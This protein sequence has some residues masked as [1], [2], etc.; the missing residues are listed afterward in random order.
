MPDRVRLTIDGRPAEAEPGASLL[1]VL[2]NEGRWLARTS[3]SGERRGPLC[4]MGACF[5]CRVTIDGE[6]HRRSCV[7]TVREGMEVSLSSRGTSAYPIPSDPPALTLTLADPSSPDTDGAPRDDRAMTGA[8]RNDGGRF[9]AEVVVVGGGPAGLAAAVHAAEAGARTLLLDDQP[10]SGGQ[11]WRHRGDAPPCAR[12]WLL[13]LAGSRAITLAAAPVVDTPSPGELLLERHGRPV[14]V[15]Y[16]RLVLAMGARELFLPFPGWT[17]PGVVGAGGASALLKAGASFDGRRV[18]VAGSGPLLVAVAAELRRAGARVVG[19]AEQ[20]SFPRLAAFAAGLWREP[21][22]LAEG[23]GHAATL[24]GVPYRTGAWVSEAVG[25]EAVERVAVTDGRREWVWECDVLACGFG[26]VP[27]LELA[28]LLGCETTSEG[29]TVGRA[30]QTSRPGVFAAGEVC[31][32][33]GVDHALAAGAIAGLAAA[34]RP[35]PGSLVARRARGA[36]FATRLARAFA[37]RDE[38]RA[39]A[40]HDTTVCRCED[41]PLDR[42]AGARSAREAKLH[43]RVGMGPCQGRVCGPALTFLHGWAPDS[44]RPP[45]LPVPLSVLEEDA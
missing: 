2:W 19:V 6:P 21:G 17:L 37:P 40:R 10:R 24:A 8:P 30:Q 13:R 38:L 12:E 45:L 9:R 16:E 5:E 14:R 26:L 36:R 44:V 22:R 3:V 23:L 15:A 4:G 39:L 35:V 43:T 29:V 25:S 32:I 7:E 20:A 18:V 31:G 42:L 34:G 27:N 1:A 33:A 11:I 41:V 28:R